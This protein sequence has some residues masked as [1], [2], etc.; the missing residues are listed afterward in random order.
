M[1]SEFHHKLHTSPI[2]FAVLSAVV[3]LV[4]T[5]VTM[6]IP[7]LTQQ[8]HP[9]LENLKP[10]TALQLAGR[11]IYQRDGCHYCHTQTVRPLKT[12]VMRYGEYSKAGE[13]AYDHPFLWGSKRTGPDLARI[14][15]KYP[16][17]WH[18]RHFE[19]P[20]AFFTE[21]NMPKYGWL[22]N[23][24]LD[25]KE[26]EARMKALDFPY[27]QDEINGLNGKTEMDALV[28][29]MQVIG[30]AVKKQVE[31]PSLAAI[32]ESHVANPLA[33]D[34]KAIEL[35][36]ALYASNCAACHGADG[37]GGIGPSLVDDEFLYVKGDVPDDD[38]FEVIN[39]GTQPG[40]IEDG[41]TA[42]GGMP[43]FG[44]SMD[45]SKIWSLVAYIRSLQGK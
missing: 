25:P 6:F 10:F 20:Q 19:N 36:K 34:P 40:M 26:V 11:D 1:A 4:G 17:A 27:S 21:S 33:G 43:P 24:I 35:G 41:R 31:M 23:N 44:T 38:Y 7:M 37:K 13:F 2:F 14:G 22:K 16:D 12:E 28:A 5:V 3:I 32:K 15:G 18:Y 8:M 42:K 45:K 29:Y 30:T 39:N 9:K